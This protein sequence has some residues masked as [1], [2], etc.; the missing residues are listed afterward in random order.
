MNNATPDGALD[1]TL[2]PDLVGDPHASGQSLSHWYNQLAYAA[3]ALNTFGDN[4]RNSL[5]GP[6]LTDVDFSLAKSFGM[7]RWEQ[8]KLM[9]RMDAINFFNHPS[10]QNPYNQINPSGLGSGGYRHNDHRSRHSAHRQILLL[11]SGRGQ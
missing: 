2:Y 1:G 11:R 5:R 9:I 3:P 6:R 8:G 7:P 10:F 4:K